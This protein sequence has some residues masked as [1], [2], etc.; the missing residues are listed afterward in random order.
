MF[1]PIDLLTF[2]VVF[3]ASFAQ[4]VVGFGF[5]LVTMAL[6]P[7]F[8]PEK[9][10]VAFVA[11]YSLGVSCMILYQMRRHI[12][13]AHAMPLLIGTILGVP[14]GILAIK[15]ADPNHVKLTLG[16]TLLAYSS[17]ALFSKI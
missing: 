2:A 5:G 11:V 13:F 4:G 7:L 8:L 17:W 6:L 15:V 12:R 9:F 3:L 10:A 16:V 1:E 14:L